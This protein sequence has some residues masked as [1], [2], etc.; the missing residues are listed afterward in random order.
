MGTVS[1]TL[2]DKFHAARLEDIVQ[3][4]EEIEGQADALM[5]E[6]LE[7]IAGEGSHQAQVHLAELYSGAGTL[8]DDCEVSL[9]ETLISKERAK[10]WSMTASTGEDFNAAFREDPKYMPLDIARVLIAIGDD[11]C[12]LRALGLIIKSAASKGYNDDGMSEL[13]QEHFADFDLEVFMGT[14]KPLPQPQKPAAP[15]E[16][17]RILI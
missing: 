15:D 16:P 9:D 2:R 8:M 14:Y 1:L 5:L 12:K 10:Y 3:R 6:Q 13:L 11:Q 17:Q 4:L 7:K